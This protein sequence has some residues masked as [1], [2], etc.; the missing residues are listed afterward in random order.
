RSATRHHDRFA[1]LFLDLDNFKT[2]ND[3]LG[4]AMGDRLLETVAHRLSACVRAEDQ[5]ARL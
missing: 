4:H 1:V 5:L 2:I 3:S